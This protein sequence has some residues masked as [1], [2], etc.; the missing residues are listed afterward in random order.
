MLLIVPIAVMLMATA[1]AGPRDAL[2][3]ELAAQAKAADPGFAGFSAD[4]GR[5]FSLEEFAQGKPDTPACTTCHTAS[6]HKPG[7]TRAGKPIEPMAVSVTPDRFTDRK[8][9]AKWFRR[10]CRSVL[11]R[12]CT[13]REKGDYL[14]FMISQ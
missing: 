6:P 14:T 9:V 3:A 10:N 12:L 7:K 13:P 5:S 2:L 8:K 1:N 11:G 4:R